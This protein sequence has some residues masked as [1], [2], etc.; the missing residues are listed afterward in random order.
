MS[1]KLCMGCM[2]HYKEQY[3]ICPYC[4]YVD[5][6][7]PKEAY[8]LSPGTILQGKYIVGKVIGYGGFGVTYIGYNA[9][10]EQKIA[11]KEYLPGEFA[12]RNGDTAD[13]TIFSGEREEQFAQGVVKFVDEAKRLAKFK[14]TP[15]IVSVY[16]S[17]QENKTA[18][19]T[20][21]CLEGETLATKL[22]R[23]GKLPLDE[24]FNLMMPVI[25][26]LKEVHKVGILHRDISPDNIFITNEHDVK[27]LDF[28]AARY[29][30]TTHSKSLSVIVKPG[31]APQ[32]QYRSRG[33]QGTW[34]DVYA[35]AATLYKMITG[36]TPEDSM[37]RGIKDTLVSPSKLGIKIPKNKENAIMNALNL[38]IED[39]TPTA[40]AFEKDLSTE[41]EVKL[42]KIKIKK[43]DVGKWPLWLKIIT[44]T[45]ATAL[46]TLA[47]LLIT[48][49][50][51]FGDL[52]I[53]DR[54]KLEAGTVYVPN[55]VNFNLIEA[56]KKTKEAELVVQIVDKMN[57]DVIPMDLVLSQNIRDG[58]VVQVGTVLEITVSAGGELV[59]LPD[60]VGM[61]QDEA[62]ATLKKLGLKY[63]LKEESS[64]IASGHIVKQDITEGTAIEKGNIIVIT[65]STGKE[66]IDDAANAIVP[67]LV[68]KSW[69]TATNDISSAKLYIYRISSEY[70]D[71]YPKGYII[72]QNVTAGT[73]VKQGSSVGV[74]V[75]LGIKKTRVPDV[76][77][78]S[79]AEAERLISEA[80]L[81]INIQYEDSN[82]VAKDHVIRQS[83]LAG[84]EVDMQTLVTVWL[85]RGNPAAENAPKYEP[86]TDNTS[87]S[88][89]NNSAGNSPSH[90][91]GNTSSTTP[92][93][94][95]SGVTDNLSGQQETVIQVT[96]TEAPVQEEPESGNI[97]VPN[98]V[99]KT[100]SEARSLLSEN[101]LVVG[102]VSYQHDETKADGTVLSQGV[103]AG[104]EVA[105]KSEINIVVCNNEQYT[106]YRYSTKT[107]KTVTNQT[108]S[109]GTLIDT[110]ES[111][112][113]WSAESTIPVTADSYTEVNT[114][115]ETQYLDNPGAP[116]P[117][118]S[119]S[120]SS[121]VT[122]YNAEIH[123]VQR[124]L[125]TY[126]G[127][128][129][130]E[131]GK[132][133]GL[134]M[135]YVGVFQEQ[136]GL[137]VDKSIGPTTT[138]RMLQVWQSMTATTT[139]YYSYRTK[140]V[141]NTYEIWSDWSVWS[142]TEVTENPDK[143]VETRKVYKY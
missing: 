24:A 125:N 67:N 68:G 9:V 87:N 33:D 31:Y 55:V 23:E 7:G 117:I 109:E 118:P 54:G 19:I 70:S 80:N 114:R 14:H 59:Y 96:T 64:E 10:L 121:Q 105:K 85:S 52:N 60:L 35:C 45:V 97:E 89:D 84:T 6:T 127:S 26:A 17:F 86:T 137:T 57:S 48:G 103:A 140:T 99:G 106:E 5:G 111:W 30:T 22:D 37:E 107:T 83:I 79:R 15:G 3:D 53:F 122:S 123:W 93:T 69:E 100:E 39:R 62:I 13:V 91:T 129:L 51:S 32:E 71:K 92:S 101:K 135:Y 104:T 11:I 94:E 73:T 126:Y 20:M 134:G 56:E 43:M 90:N 138:A 136:Q 133:G 116:L 63:Q 108:L 132:Y 143:K 112:S 115:T 49:I 119:R 42:N 8:H 128:I 18:Y 102:V 98:L 21:E 12:T 28:G 142:T 58:E 75:S 34:T 4:G 88:N 25:G 131:D 61:T 139:T 38:R 130:T 82:T 40:D 124:F 50:I 2:K 47:T 76:Q 113:T 74:V 120:Y 81:V 141:T 29:A 95:N 65:V 72:S 41:D 46:V 77:F 110:Q 44:G 78:K 66:D 16:D 1:Q 27:L 36:V